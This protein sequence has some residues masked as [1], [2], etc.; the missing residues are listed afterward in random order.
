MIS[1]TLEY[2]LRASLHL[3]GHE[4]VPQTTQQIALA[5]QMPAAFLSK[6]LQSLGRAGLVQ[7]QRGLRGGYVLARSPAELTILEIAQLVDPL[8]R[9]HACPLGRAEH[10][11]GL[12][13]LHRRLDNVLA[14]AEESFRKTTLAELLQEGQGAVSALGCPFPCVSQ[15]HVAANNSLTGVAVVEQVSS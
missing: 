5:I 3:A 13:P 11:I 1:Q 7:S 15:S 4:G 9:I 14:L 2:A 8:K 12:C 6:V 10:A